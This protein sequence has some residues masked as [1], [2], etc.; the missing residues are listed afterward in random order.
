M[1]YSTSANHV[2][3]CSFAIILWELCAWKEPYEGLSSMAVT[4]AVV[5]GTRPSAPEDCPLEIA[6]VMNKCWREDQ[7]ARCAPQICTNLDI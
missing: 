1:A 7:H 6:E 3:L 5:R 4:N 2:C